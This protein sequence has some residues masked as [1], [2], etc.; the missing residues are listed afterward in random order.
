METSLRMVIR[1]LHDARRVC[2]F[3][4]GTTV[5][6][7]IDLVRGKRLIQP[8]EPDDLRGSPKG[9]IGEIDQEFYVARAY[10]KATEG[11]QPF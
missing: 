2:F 6:L 5:F 8:I 4:V 11:L 10:V 7:A 3:N 1:A 9:C